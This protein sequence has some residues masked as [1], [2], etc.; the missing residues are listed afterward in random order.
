[1]KS[2]FK[3]EVAKKKDKVVLVNKMDMPKDFYGDM[4]SAF[5]SFDGKLWI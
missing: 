5:I 2:L 4:E 1:M 3:K